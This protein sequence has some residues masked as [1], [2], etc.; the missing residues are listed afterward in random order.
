MAPFSPALHYP[1]I[2]TCDVHDVAE[3]QKVNAGATGGGSLGMTHWLSTSVRL[4]INCHLQ[5]P[6]EYVA[7]PRVGSGLQPRHSVR[8]HHFPD[9]L[10]T[11]IRVQRKARSRHAFSLGFGQVRRTPP[12]NSLSIGVPRYCLPRNSCQP[13]GRITS[14]LPVSCSSPI[15][16]NHD[17]AHHLPNLCPMPSSREAVRF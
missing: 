11:V 16:L 2:P 8:C 10:K 6:S 5:R 12:A 13:A 7:A 4:L 15:T 17:I 14:A 9:S 1:S 3:A